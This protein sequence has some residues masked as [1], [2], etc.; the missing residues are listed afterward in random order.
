MSRKAAERSKELKMSLFS[1]YVGLDVH[2]KIDQFL[3]E[4]C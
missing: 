4:A 3:R 1:Y 2:R